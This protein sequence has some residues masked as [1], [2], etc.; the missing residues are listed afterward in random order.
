M[1]LDKEHICE[2]SRILYGKMK[3][4]CCYSFNELQKL[5]N[6]ESTDLCLALIRLLQENKI[7]QDRAK[8]GICY[9]VLLEIAFIIGNENHPYCIFCNRGDFGKTRI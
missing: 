7:T 3:R 2:N 6:F 5:T 1:V 8:K 9:A 4:M